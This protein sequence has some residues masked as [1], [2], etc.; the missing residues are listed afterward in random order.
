MTDQRRTDQTDDPP[1]PSQA[2]G[3]RDTIEQDLNE[4]SDKR[5]AVG[6]TSSAGERKNDPPRPSQAEGEREVGEE[7]EN[8]A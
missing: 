2:E 7:S 1:R 5:P 4:R 8:K 6:R 3:E